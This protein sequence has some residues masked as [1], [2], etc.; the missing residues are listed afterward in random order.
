[1]NLGN[2]WPISGVLGMNLGLFGPF[3]A[4]FRDLTLDLGPIWAILEGL[5]MN[6]GHFWPMLGVLGMDLGL[7]SQDS[8]FNK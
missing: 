6:L 1:M 2:F 3:S 5:A 4:Y 8:D 7:W